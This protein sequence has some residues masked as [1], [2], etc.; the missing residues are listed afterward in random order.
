MIKRPCSQHHVEYSSTLRFSLS[1]TFYQV[2]KVVNEWVQYA[3]KTRLL[4]TS[5]T[6]FSIKYRRLRSDGA[7][8]KGTPVK[9]L[10]F[11]FVSV[12]L[13][14]STGA[15]V[16]QAQNNPFRQTGNKEV[17][18]EAKPPQT[19]VA[20]SEDVPAVT[21]LAPVL[22]AVPSSKQMQSAKQSQR[23]K[24]ESL[25]PPTTKAWVSIPDANLLLEKFE[26]SNLGKLAAIPELT[27]FVDDVKSQF[28]NYIDEKN[29][30]LGISLSD[31][32]NVRTGEVAFAGVLESV[33]PESSP[34]F[35]AGS[36]GI[37]ILVDVAGN[38][39][40][41]TEL[42]DKVSAEMKSYG[43]TKEQP[44]SVLGFEISRW[45]VPRRKEP[46]LKFD[47]FQ[48]I[49]DGW[50]VA[51][52]S[53][54]VLREVL[55]RIKNDQSSA[56]YRSLVDNES[57]AAIQDRSQ[58]SDF[59]ADLR[60]F[61]E[62]FGYIDLAQAIRAQETILK[63]RKH[64]Y[65]GKLRQHGFDALRGVGGMISINPDDFD[66]AYRLF[67]YTAGSQYQPEA[68][69]RALDILDIS[70]S[71][72]DKLAPNHFVSSEYS[73][74]ALTWNM[75]KAY[76]NVGPLVDAFGGEDF[77]KSFEKSFETDIGVN[78]QGLISRLGSK[79]GIISKTQDGPTDE[80]ERMAIVVPLLGE[81]QEH[82]NFLAEIQ[83]L[84]KIGAPQ[85]T[86]SGL[87]YLEDSRDADEPEE[88]D[89]PRRLRLNR[90]EQFEEKPKTKETSTEGPEFKVFKRRYFAVIDGQLVIASHL[91]LLEDFSGEKG[92]GKLVS[93]VDYIYASS[94]I[95]KL[96]GTESVS[97]R[98]F[99]RLDRQVKANYFAFREGKMGQSQTSL[100]RVLNRLLSLDSENPNYVR[101]QRVDGSG[102]PE[103]FDGLI[104]PYLGF[105][106][107]A[108][109]TQDDGWLIS[110]GIVKK[111]GVNELVQREE[112]TERR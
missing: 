26:Q 84:L 14:A 49:A 76:N 110:G 13:G 92:R 65:A 17:E 106:V 88:E 82:E 3:A 109:E 40:A 85:T 20:N 22:P 36:H 10:I 56:T 77:F 19:E 43:A 62:P 34:R 27:S 35:T 12:L 6:N 46:E 94:T 45:K 111:K 80:N 23:A 68:R 89:D 15:A 104:A 30:R 7:D 16:L 44:E 105:G 48:T 55:L 38:E 100:G 103:D 99:G 8:T 67:A 61:I 83:K 47:T 87:V 102:L 79:I 1:Q 86:Q 28:N 41:A 53:Q 11:F 101:E 59:E 51:T 50:F 70:N 108:L 33:S 42:L 2:Q 24:S 31:I 58:L 60:W 74:I 29:I 4:Q 63:K 73:H 66:I 57:F 93:N 25:L 75:L 90:F 32:R 21:G 72:Q 54:T 112:D 81:T 37:V 39:A 97:L 52:D 5:S 96:L 9:S 78:L 18:R 95:S 107:I 91:D 71:A 98:G 64:D 69:R